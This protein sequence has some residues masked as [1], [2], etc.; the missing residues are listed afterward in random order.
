M[1]KQKVQITLFGAN[2]ERTLEINTRGGFFTRG[3]KAPRESVST[4]PSEKPAPVDPKS[5]AMPLSQESENPPTLLE[6][7]RYMEASADCAGWLIIDEILFVATTMFKMKFNHNTLLDALRELFKE[8]FLVYKQ[9]QFGQHTFRLIE[10]QVASHN[11]K[12]LL[13]EADA[14]TT[15]SS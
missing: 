8:G 7:L 14:L 9:N 1:K 2:G 5:E 3:I 12:N 6:V 15:Y 10:K 4:S 13:A 11:L